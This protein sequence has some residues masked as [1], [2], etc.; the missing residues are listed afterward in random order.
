MK[1]V[2]LIF[3]LVSLMEVHQTQAQAHNL[4]DVR[5]MHRIIEIQEDIKLKPLIAYGE[6]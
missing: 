4:D 2:V 1:I 6:N 3:L 5:E